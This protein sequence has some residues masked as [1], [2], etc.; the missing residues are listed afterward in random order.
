[1]FTGLSSATRGWAPTEWPD[2]SYYLGDVFTSTL[3]TADLLLGIQAIL[4]NALVISFYCAS[5]KKVVPFMYLLIATCDLATGIAAVLTAVI[6]FTMKNNLDTALYILPVAYTIFS[7]TF[8]VSVYLNLVIAVV[9][10]IN[11]LLPFYRIRIRWI[12]IVTVIYTLSWLSFTVRRVQEF[13]FDTFDLFQLYSPGQVEVVR[14]HASTI[15]LHD[16]SFVLL[17]IGLIFVLPACVAVV[18]MIIQ[19]RSIL[20]QRTGRTANT[21][22]QRQM[23]ITIFALTVLF[24]FCN[25]IFVAYPIQSCLD[26]HNLFDFRYVYVQFMKMYML[27]HITGFLCPFINAAFNPVILAV[28]GEALSMYLKKMLQ[29]FCTVWWPQKPNH[30]HPFVHQKPQLKET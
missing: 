13:H 16:C 8:K 2:N 10:T 24:F 26:L 4:M 18:C 7:V 27:A 20:K 29:R 6:F 15:I 9:R 12:S 17:F 25:A 11:I 1:M 14:Y 3:G 23:T 21:D 5:Y 28:R 30:S 19:I 22:K